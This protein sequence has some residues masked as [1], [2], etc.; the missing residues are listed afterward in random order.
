[1]LNP[2]DLR[3]PEFLLFYLLLSICVMVALVLTRRFAEAGEPTKINL[4]DPYQI[5]FLRG[6]APEVA[7]L[8]A[9]SLVDRGF[10]K[11]QDQELIYNRHKRGDALKAPIEQQVLDSFLGGAVPSALFSKENKAR[12]VP[13]MAIYEGQLARLN[14]LPD[15][16]VKATRRVRLLL[17]IGL[18]WGVALVKIL[19]AIERGRGN[20]GFLI[21]LALI[22]AAICVKL[23]SPRLTSR[24]EAMLAGLD[25]LFS[26][27]KQRGSSL[28]PGRQPDELLLLGAVFGAAALPAT[29][30]PHVRTLFPKAS[31]QS[32]SSGSSCGSSCGSSSSCGGGGDGGGSSC[33]GGG[34]CGG[35]G[36]GGGD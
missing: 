35:C 30:A 23:A 17:A 16:E 18:L 11:V 13:H 15:A 1:M 19:I 2:F 9:V 34:G 33:G 26:S 29:A 6:G 27:L 28:S 7:R 31:S 24:G 20:Y 10:L 25:G 32:N 21:A 3:G 4:S 36:G 8:A 14:L 12:F 5:A 22:A